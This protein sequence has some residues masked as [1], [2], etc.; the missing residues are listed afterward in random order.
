MTQ[1][2]DQSDSLADILETYKMNT[3]TTRSSN[4]YGAYQYPE[5]LFPLMI[6]NALKD[7]VLPLYCN[8]RNIRYWIIVYE[9]NQKVWK[10]F[11]NRK[12]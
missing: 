10:A 7:K 1:K 11:L 4:N 3:A 12:A 6:S 2:L 9:H 5:N 8:G